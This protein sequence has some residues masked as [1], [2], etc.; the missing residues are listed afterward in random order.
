MKH[1][2]QLTFLLLVLSSIS[3]RKFVFLFK[4]NLQ[5]MSKLIGI[6]RNSGAGCQ[7]SVDD[8]DCVF[9]TPATLENVVN[10]FKALGV[11]FEQV[12]QFGAVNAI[13]YAFSSEEKGYKNIKLRL[14]VTGYYDF[15]F[16]KIDNKITLLD[17]ICIDDPQDCVNKENACDD[18]DCLAVPKQTFKS[19]INEAILSRRGVAKLKASGSKLMF[20]FVFVIPPT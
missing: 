10:Q 15:Y 9:P 14:C 11:E 6:A 4:Q 2:V 7:I 12:D 3:S 20:V 19:S 1:L 17:D 8:I 16:N 18:A 13:Y 5:D